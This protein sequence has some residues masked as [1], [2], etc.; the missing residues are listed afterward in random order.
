MIMRSRSR[1]IIAAKADEDKYDDST[2]TDDWHEAENEYRHGSTGA[3]NLHMHIGGLDKELAREETGNIHRG[4]QHPRGQRRHGG[5][6]PRSRPWWTAFDLLTQRWAQ[7][8][9][10]GRRHTRGLLT[11]RLTLSPDAARPWT[12]WSCCPTQWPRQVMPPRRPT[13]PPGILE[14]AAQAMIYRPLLWTANVLPTQ[15]LMLPLFKA[16]AP[17]QTPV[18]AR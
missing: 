11:S 3:R 14:H 17:A 15:W 5:I 10:V 6:T 16:L 13:L 12:S 7:S 2:D 8:H 9:A 1:A 4:G 18:L